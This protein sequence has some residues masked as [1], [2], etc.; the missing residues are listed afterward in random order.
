MSFNHFKEAFGRALSASVVFFLFFLFYNTEFVRNKA[1]DFAFDFINKVYI[2]TS[3]ISMQSP[4]VQLFAIDDLYMKGHQ[5]YDDHNKSNYGYLFPRKYIADFI[6]RLDQLVQDNDPANRPKALFIDYD[7][8]FTAMP[9]GKELSVDDQVLLNTLKQQRSYSILL[10][11]TS[12]Y[13][14]I[15]KSQDKEIQ[16]RISEKKIIFVSVSLLQTIDGMIRRYEGYKSFDDK[17]Y[18]SVDIALWQVLNGK[19]IDL[20][21]SKAHFLRN[22]IIGNRIWMKS[23]LSSSIDD[24]CSIQKSYWENLTKYS[25]NCSLYDVIQEDFAGS[26]VMLGGTHTQND[27]RFD[28]LNV[29]SKES[30]TGIDIHA[31]TLMTMVYQ[32]G[33]LQRLPLWSSL[34]VVFICF[35]IVSM[36]VSVA[37]SFFEGSHQKIKFFALLFIN[38]SILL[39]ISNYLLHEYH[40]WF[41][42]LIASASF[43]LIKIF[44][45]L[46]GGTT[47]VITKLKRNQR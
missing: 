46:K 35:F 25:A 47:K 43:E 10:P 3:P 20:E 32:N 23:Y 33:S 6:Q 30:F 29:F 36:I 1:E 4:Q 12:R 13:N 5:L 42:W 18:M 9:Y 21:S 22:D 28:M 24:G 15:E 7:M 40:M 14:F 38:T 8:S 41:N 27:D 11:K 16:K 26:V 37:L 39:F 34:I 31:N 44:N 17:E 45:R 19:D 2:N